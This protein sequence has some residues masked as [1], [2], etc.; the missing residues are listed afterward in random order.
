MSKKIGSLWLRQTKDGKKY[1]SGVLNDLSGDIQIAIFPNDRKEKEN[2]PDFQ[3][4]LYEKREERKA[5]PSGFDGLTPTQKIPSSEIPVV[6]DNPEEIDIN[7][8]PF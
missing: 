1:M 6:E 4:V 3:I 2:Q 7:Q 5:A 8:I